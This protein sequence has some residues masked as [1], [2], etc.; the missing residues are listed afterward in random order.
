MEIFIWL[1]LIPNTFSCGKRTPR[2][3]V[4]AKA[5]LFILQVYMHGLFVF[6]FSC[7][8][9]SYIQQVLG[10]GGMLVSVM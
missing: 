7:V 8:H 3:F 9:E 1:F 4:V 10:N 5:L 6:E 2:E